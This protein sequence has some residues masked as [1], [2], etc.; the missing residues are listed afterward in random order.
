MAAKPVRQG[1]AVPW[2]AQQWSPGT[3]VRPALPV[4]AL[5]GPVVARLRALA[6]AAGA[7]PLC[8]Y[9]H[10][11]SAAARRAA[12]LRTRLPAWAEV[13]YAVKAN[14]FPAT[15]RAL[16]PETD[17]FDVSSEGEAEA[18]RAAGARALI[19]TGPGKT[20]AMLAAVAAAG[21]D[22]VSA[23]SEL[24]LHR[25]AAAARRAGRRVPVVLRVNA[26][27]VP[28]QGALRMDGRA[29]QFGIGEDG[30]ARAAAV[31]RALPGLD[32]AGYHFHVVSNN[33]D[34]E[35]HAAHVLGRLRW[36]VR[37]A[38]EHGFAL[39]VVDAGG[40]LGV[41]PRG[42]AP[43]DLA[44][45][46][47]RLR[48][49]PPPP[50]IRLVLEPGRWLVADSAHYA[51]QVTDVK[52]VAGSRFAVLAGGINHFMLPALLEV[53]LDAAV[54]DVARWPYACAR[55]EVHD[56]VVSLAG[57]LCTP[58]DILARGIGVGRL[59]AGDLV[60]FPLAGAY[61]AEFALHGF[62]GRR[63]P[64]HTVAGG[65]QT[66]SARAGTASAP[67]APSTDGRRPAEDSSR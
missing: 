52:E 18:A 19:A 39:R 55:P 63:P 59:R 3:A 50:G 45:F 41:A 7:E 9:V 60:V 1:G 21:A 27:T 14:S 31:A 13:F 6:E 58:E 46:A 36:S 15:L 64:V 30:L 28:L 49:A 17:G 10:D 4:S 62:L 20:D 57:P 29:T 66:V 12:L 2:P 38:R 42:E 16:A 54:V 53:A 22:F 51:A 61:G 56:A 43:F 33:L 23:E 34:A 37:A 48:A 35:G 5:P 47:A 44:H 25:I 26:A 11:P 40:G 8:A 24:D 67:G 65:P 32:L